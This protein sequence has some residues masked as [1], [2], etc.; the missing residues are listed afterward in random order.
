MTDSIF[1]PQ[2]IW[3]HRGPL[4]NTKKA[5]KNGK[6][7]VGYMGGSISDGR[8]FNKWPEAVTAWLVEKFPNVQIVSE[9]SA[10][11]ATSS[12]LA[13]FR[14]ERDI[15]N[16]GCDL[17][18]IEYAA[19][20]LGIEPTRRARHREGLLR[21]LLRNG[22]CDVVCVYTFMQEMYEEM[23]Q[24]QV[25]QTIADFEKLCEHYNLGSI[26]MGQYALNEVLKGRMRWEE[27]LPDALHPTER[28][29]FSYAQ[30]VTSF[31]EKE[32]SCDSETESINTMPA[33]LDPLN[34]EETEL[35]PFEKM[36]CTG[37][38]FIR[39]SLDS[40]FMDQ[41]LSTSAP[42]STIRVEFEGRAVLGAFDFGKKSAEVQYS[43]DGGPTQVSH[44]D[45]LDWV[46]DCGLF[47]LRSF[48]E[49]L[50]PGK[51][52]LELETVNTSKLFFPGTRCDLAFI[53]VVK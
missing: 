22:N 32:F 25:P 30:S 23:I 47:L 41:L 6:L 50:E 7:T 31:L 10:I 49:N 8:G 17:V 34:W 51:H 42:G 36:R 40:V 52:V 46:P 3:K 4:R 13:L 11:G 15:I 20:D 9:N 19:N 2:R 29:S 24:G 18:F 39:R 43:I 44:F 5:I 48:G 16:R 14:A 28:G 21:K 38:W 35:I 37:P 1:Q 53:G 27:W 45:K 26:W 33:P 12:D